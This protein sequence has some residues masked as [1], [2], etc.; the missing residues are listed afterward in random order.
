MKKK[1]K[2][3][4]ISFVLICTILVIVNHFRVRTLYE[5]F[6]S[7]KVIT[8]CETL[9]YDKIISKNLK[10]DRLEIVEA[11]EIRE[12]V[13]LVKNI[14]IKRAIFEPVRTQ[15]AVYRELRFY[16]Y[17]SFYSVNIFFEDS[18]YLKIIV[19]GEDYYFKIKDSKECERLLEYIDYEIVGIKLSSK[20]DC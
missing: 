1:L 2:Y 11:E 6:N 18:D 13:N 7:D 4:I 3:S 9:V 17:S 12:I 16:D 19:E 10:K 15:A 14:K 5:F 8:N 20:I